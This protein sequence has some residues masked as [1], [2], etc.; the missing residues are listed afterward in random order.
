MKQFAVIHGKCLFPKIQ[1]SSYT[2]TKKLLGLW[3]CWLYHSVRWEGA[4]VVARDHHT[5]LQHGLE[6][7]EV[8]AVTM[9]HLK[10]R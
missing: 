3:E 1:T 5:A 6:E 4:P 10:A 8:V 2:F 9:S 7:C